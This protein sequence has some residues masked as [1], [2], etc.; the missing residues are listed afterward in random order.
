[1]DAGWCHHECTRTWHSRAHARG[2]ERSGCMRAASLPAVHA[3]SGMAEAHQPRWTTAA[4]PVD[5]CASCTQLAELGVSVPTRPRTRPQTRPRTRPR[6]PCRAAAASGELEVLRWLRAQNPPCPWDTSTFRASARAGKL[7]V[8]RW[9]QEQQCP[10]G[11]S[12]CRAAAGAGELEALRWL[13]A[14]NLPCPWNVGTVSAAAIGSHIAVLH[15]LRGQLPPCRWKR[16]VCYDAICSGSL[17]SLLWLRKQA[18]P[19]PWNTQR[20]LALMR[21]ATFQ[22]LHPESEWAAAV[23]WLELEERADAPGS[24]ASTCRGAARW[25]GSARMRSP[26]AP[27]CP[28]WTW[29]GALH[30]RRSA[31]GPLHSASRSACCLSMQTGSK[32][33]LE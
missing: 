17:E 10:W 8:L 13:R 19:C 26:S 9:L 2:T 16:S 30:W 11:R 18:P 33:R 20:C 31:R 22:R 5:M 29:R 21:G 15:W 28:P 14:E 27:S 6:T 12:T 3:T 24:P 32:R 23:Q 1:V 4:K 7:E 25:L